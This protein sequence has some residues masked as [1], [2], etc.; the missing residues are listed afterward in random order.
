MTGVFSNLASQLTSLSW[1]AGP[2]FTKELRVSSRR[3]RNYVLRSAYLVLLTVFLVLVWFRAVSYSASPLFRTSRMAEAGKAVVTFIVWF[4]FCALQ[5]VAVVMLST[6]I[7]DE[8]H[9]RTL[10]LLMTTPISS[11]QIVM[12]KLLSRLLH[13]MLLMAVSL[14]LLAIARLFGGVPWAYIISSLCITLTTVIFVASLSLFFSIFLHRAHV[15]IIMTILTAAALFALVPFLTP[16]LA[17]LIWDFMPFNLQSTIAKGTFT[18]LFFHPNPYIT[19]FANTVSVLEPRAMAG[20]A[21]FSWPLH[22]AIMLAASALVLTVAVSLVRKVALSQSVGRLDTLE[23]TVP[24]KQTALD[25][26]P[27]ELLRASIRRISGPPIIWRQLHTQ[28]FRRHRTGVFVIIAILL[29]ATFLMYGFMAITNRLHDRQVHTLIV[30]ILAGLGMLFTT[31]LP[32]TTITSEK[33]ARSW[34]LL[35]TT[36]LSDN[37]I[38]FGKFTGAL[39]RCLPTWSFLF[40]HL[41]FSVLVGLLHPIVIAQMAILVAW[42]VT[43]LCCTGLYFS[44]RFRHNAAAVAMNFALVAAVWGLLPVL[45]VMFY[46]AARIGGT[47]FGAF[48]RACINA[49]PLFQGYLLVGATLSGS[50]GAASYVWFD[51]RLDAMES[52]LFMLAF[53]A[54]YMFLAWIFAWRAKCRFRRNIF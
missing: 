54:L 5:L 50:H 13:V 11:F 18:V 23:P 21:F 26:V 43:F 30:V 27:A 20:I 28:W 37:A 15:V 9:N 36:T 4:Q 47:W 6:A 7:S 39:C 12:G 17:S 40:A 2:I 32:A 35:L 8:I 16:F 1:L 46:N 41:I 33:Q 24:K 14:S 25:D 38:L 22:C 49:N 3:K 52:T 10:G 44:S 42:I 19:F 31:L 53:M 51:Q 48:A 34:P 45:L 29:V